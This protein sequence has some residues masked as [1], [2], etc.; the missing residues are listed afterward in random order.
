MLFRKKISNRY[1]LPLPPRNWDCNIQRFFAHQE[2]FL[3]AS[4]LV[5]WMS[6]NIMFILCVTKGQ[7]ILFLFKEIE[8]LSSIHI[9]NDERVRKYF[10][11]FY[12][13]VSWKAFFNIV[14]LN[15]T[16]SK[17]QWVISKETFLRQGLQDPFLIF[18]CMFLNPN[19]FFQFKL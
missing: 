2:N 10:F 13:Y 18:S 4:A 14:W 7:K 8:E 15:D 3:L 17:S 9:L 12:D 5:F 11:L 1:D 6:H 16:T 19:N